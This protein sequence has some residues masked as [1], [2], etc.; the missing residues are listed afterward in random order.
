MQNQKPNEDTIASRF[1]WTEYDIF[2]LPRKNNKKEWNLKF[3]TFSGP[4]ERS[5]HAQ[6]LVNMQM[7]RCFSFSLLILSLSFRG[8]AIKRVHQQKNM[9]SFSIET[10]SSEEKRKRTKL[11][12]S[13][14]HFHIKIWQQ[15]QKEKWKWSK[16]RENYR[17]WTLFW[18][19]H[20]NFISRWRMTCVC[21][22]IVPACVIP[23]IVNVATK[24]SPKSQSTT[25]QTG[26]ICM[27]TQQQRKQRERE[28][29]R[30]H[31]KNE[32]VS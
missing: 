14:I 32:C 30:Q 9:L 21:V 10:N 13:N 6:L 2:R 19:W 22:C 7:C 31:I 17:S 23:F 15:K 8:K 27:W 5:Y 24:H 11:T 25:T 3:N 12:R 4:S 1:T 26:H 18:P 20:F 16:K 28:L 29:N